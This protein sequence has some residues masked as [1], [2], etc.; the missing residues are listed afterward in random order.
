M[1]NLFNRTEYSFRMAYGHLEK[2]FQANEGSGFIGICDRHGTWGHVAFQKF[3]LKNNLKPVFGV[4]LILV[5]DAELLEQQPSS[6]V[7]FIAKNSDGLQEMYNLVSESTRDKHHYYTPRIG[8]KQH[9]KTLSNNVYIVTSKPIELD[10]YDN[11]LL[12]LGPVTRPEGIKWAKEKGIRPIA[13]SDNYYPRPEHKDAYEV[14][15]GAKAEDKTTAMHI[16]NEWEWDMEVK[17]PADFKQLALD[18]A[19][20]VAEEVDVHLPKAKLVKH[21]DP[22]TLEQ[23]CREGAVSRGIDLNDPVYAARLKRE[24]DLIAEKQF[25][26]YFYLI[27]DMIVEAKKTMLVGPARGSSCGSLVC[28]LLYI[29]DID[30]IP[31]NL[32][33]ERFIDINRKDLPDIDIDFPDSKRDQ[34][35]E[36]LKVKYGHDCV[37]QLGTVNRYKA[38]STI[39][40]V[41][42]ELNIP[43]SDVDDLKDAILERSGGDSRANFCII[44]TFKSLDIGKKTLEKYPEL[45]IA[46]DIEAHARH[47]GKHAAGLIVTAEPVNRYCSVDY[48]T[49]AAQVD[50]YD[51]EELDLLKIDALGLRTLSVIEDCLDQIGKSNDWLLNYPLDDQKAFDV[52]N[53]GRFTGIFQF[54]GSALQALANQM[55]VNQ[56]EDVVALTALARPGPLVSGMANEWIQRRIGNSAVSFEHKMLEEILSYNYGIV[57]YQEDIM[58][59]AREIGQLTWE[60]VSSLRKAM[61]KSL[62]KEFFD[63]YKIKFLAGAEVNNY[64][65]KDAENLWDKM[66]TFGSWAFNRSHAVAYG[67][68]S[69]WCMLLKAHYPLEYAAATLRHAKDDDQIIKFLRELHNEGIEY[70]AFDPELSEANWSVKNGVIIGGLVGV[71]GIGPKIAQSIVDRRKEGKEL[72]KG[73]LNKLEGATTPWDTIFPCQER[74]GHIKENPTAH[75][76]ATKISNI[77]DIKTDSEGQFLIIGRLKKKNQR[78]KNELI[79]IKKRNGKIYEGQ[80]LYLNCTFED[81]TDAIICSISTTKYMKYGK[82]IVEDGKEGDWYL[83]KGKNIPG[84]RLISVDRIRKLTAEDERKLS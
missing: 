56:F 84:I 13:S 14:C 9:L 20:A 25:E 80:S 77:I 3:C 76:I 51:A 72:T 16:L 11:V 46:A 82:P 39:G 43:L 57:V 28:Y 61:S 21:D 49:G 52:L 44:D 12:D 48:Q 78:D 19:K 70:K 31:Y 62:G 41:A 36:Y 6:I 42:K 68:V 17:A 10:H 64:P 54:E 60:D 59:I 81:D 34:V 75:N 66:N 67:V 33:F 18:T 40:D 53:N 4:E 55:K 74:W 83:I 50:K 26:D 15:I 65:V 45:I 23:I 35:F 69:Y 73:Q 5:D 30:P 47:S 58:R 71:K 22:R 24:L 37:A 63:Q 1:I 79:N 2:V 8:V 32:L 29:T 27:A 7:R 38:K